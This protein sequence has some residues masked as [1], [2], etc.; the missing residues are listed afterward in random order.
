[1]PPLNT[2]TRSC[3]ALAIGHAAVMSTH[4]ANIL[5]NSNTDVDGMD[6]ICTLR[7][8]IVSANTNPGNENS[9]CVS[10]AAGMDTISFDGTIGS[11]ILLTQNTHLAITED[12]TING[13]GEDL[14]TIDGNANA[15]VFRMDSA[16]VTLNDMTISNGSRTFSGGIWVRYSN[17]TMSNVTVSGN[18]GFNGGG[19]TIEDSSVT[20]ENSTVTGNSVRDAGNS[21]G[22]YIRGASNVNILNS[23]ISNNSAPTAAGIRIVNSSSL[24]ISNSSVTGNSAVNN[25]GGIGVYA[26]VEVINSTVSG[27]TAAFGGGL[28]VYAADT[29][30][31]T[32]ST[33]VENIATSRGGAMYLFGG[34]IVLNNSLIAGNNA[35]AAI[36]PG[37]EIAINN[38]SSPNTVLSNGGNLFGDSS[39]DD[40]VAFKDF[41]PNVADITATSDGDIS[42]AIESILAPLADNGGPT[43]THALVNDSPALDNADN[44][45]CG[46]MKVI[47]TDQRGELREDGLCDIGSFEGIIEDS[48]FFVVP[49]SNGKVVIFGL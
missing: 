35:T 36:D 27:N 49:L 28:F 46:D 1:M 21:G 32:N 2:F 45:N 31:L 41:T 43:Q 47:N 23:T 22:I 24:N 8:A 19:M 30:T 33:L 5:V 26:T 29:A 14:L 6:V 12:L 44:T 48:S 4:A 10:G 42:T 7:E 34:S 15:G 9:G 37:A 18:E 16:T 11:T 39:H 3:L 13:I 38:G 17:L 40:S 25:T 20:I